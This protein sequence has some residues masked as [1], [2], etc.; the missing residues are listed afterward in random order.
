MDI[1]TIIGLA[2]SI[3][4]VIFT[5]YLE[6]SHLGSFMTFSAFILIAVGSMTISITCFGLKDGFFNLPNYF[7]YVIF[8]PKVDIQAQVVSFVNYSEKA[9]REGLLSLEDDI[10]TITDM[11][12]NKGLQ[13][14]I[15]GADPETVR[16]I[17]EEMADNMNK[18]D[19]LA[20]EVFETL[21]GYSPTLGIVGT[22]MGLV[23]VL[24]NLGSGNITALGEGI[25]VAFIA[26]FYGI[27]FANLIWLP[28]VTKVRTIVGRL[29][30]A[31]AIIISG[32]MSIQSGD[33]PS[34]V[35]D[36]LLC[37]ISDPETRE[38]INKNIK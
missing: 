37:H 33:N 19:K 7:R 13:L 2:G 29:S 11:M 10:N 31:R 28:L 18:H 3:T 20:A 25:A 36:K 22:V 12:T 35:K 6:G 4:A 34:I 9:R 24:E 38:K 23:H 32:I 16:N 26:T 21:G 14:V 30:E 1:S 17:L 27:G 5:M 8:P 15:D